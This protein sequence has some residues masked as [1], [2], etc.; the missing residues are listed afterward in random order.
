MN[1]ILPED[2]AQLR[3]LDSLDTMVSEDNRVRI[4]DVLLEKI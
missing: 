2:R 4:I 3:M 1:F